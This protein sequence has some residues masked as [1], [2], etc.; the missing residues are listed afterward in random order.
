MNKSINQRYNCRFLTNKSRHSCPRFMKLCAWVH[1]RSL[2]IYVYAYRNLIS[3]S[4][5][6]KWRL[7]RLSETRVHGRARR[8]T[9]RCALDC[10][11][12]AINGD[13]PPPRCANADD[14]TRRD[15]TKRTLSVSHAVQGSRCKAERIGADHAR[16]GNARFY[17]VRRD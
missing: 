8:D 17:P 4:R 9:R 6:S 15:E 7:A 10:D 12:Y 5:V 13:A 1:S 16:R 14:A 3:K 11:H 2:C